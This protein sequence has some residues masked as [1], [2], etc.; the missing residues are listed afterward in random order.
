[1]QY[2]KVRHLKFLPGVR[3]VQNAMTKYI[4]LY[5]LSIG[6]DFCAPFTSDCMI[7]GRKPVRVSSPWFGEVLKFLFL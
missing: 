4:Y 3:M 7:L 2:K 1:M 5:N 6:N